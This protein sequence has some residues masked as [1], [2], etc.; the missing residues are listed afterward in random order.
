MT[1]VETMFKTLLFSMLTEDDD[2]GDIYIKCKKTSRAFHHFKKYNDPST[3][4]PCSDEEKLAYFDE[5]RDEIL[6]KDVM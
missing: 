3:W 5:N 1:W 4:K 6:R 2:D